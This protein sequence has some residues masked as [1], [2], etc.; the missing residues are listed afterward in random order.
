MFYLDDGVEQGHSCPTIPTAVAVVCLSQQ[1]LDLIWLLQL[2]LGFSLLFVAGIG[3]ELEQHKAGQNI[4]HLLQHNWEKILISIHL[5]W[6]EVGYQKKLHKISC[7][8]SSGVT[9]ASFGINSSHYSCTHYIRTIL[10]MEA[11][12]ERSQLTMLYFL[13]DLGER[14]HNTPFWKHDKVLIW[15]AILAK[16]VLTTEQDAPLTKLL[17]IIQ[18]QLVFFMN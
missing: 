4:E 16:Q 8:I 9:S 12:T 15:C 11:I 17:H 2:I 18:Y 6:G 5:E 13:N 1:P 3:L 10:I 14:F 7:Y